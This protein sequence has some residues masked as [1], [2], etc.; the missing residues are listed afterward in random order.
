MNFRLR[1]ERF[2][3]LHDPSD[4][5]CHVGGGGGVGVGQSHVYHEDVGQ[6]T[7]GW[8]GRR[9]WRRKRQ[10]GEMEKKRKENKN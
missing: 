5:L 4:K 10:K 3:P 2:E 9:D 6:D 1:R 8:A 7:R